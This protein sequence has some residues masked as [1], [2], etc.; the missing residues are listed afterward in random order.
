MIATKNL[1]YSFSSVLVKLIPKKDDIT[2]IKNLRPISLLS[3]FYKI[4]SS[5]YSN[6]LKRVYDKIV[7][8]RQK[9]YSSQKILQEA[10]IDVLD[11]IKK[12]I[13]ND[14]L[15]GNVLI[16]FRKAFDT[17]SHSYILKSLKFFNFSDY[18]IDVAETLL[19]GRRGSVLI[20]T[21]FFANF[22]RRPRSFT[23]TGLSYC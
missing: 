13:V 9:A 4:P 15:A 6:R 3:V 20:D 22:W 11:N 14:S 17:I 7:S 12:C 21:G 1:N 5:A 16:D 19:T 8:K 18:M 23:L 2:H 10:V